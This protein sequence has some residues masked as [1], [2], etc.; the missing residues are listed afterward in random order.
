MCG[1]VAESANRRRGSSLKPSKLARI[2]RRRACAIDEDARVTNITA[3][4]RKPRIKELRRGAWRVRGA[5]RTVEALGAALILPSSSAEIIVL[6]S[7]LRILSILSFALSLAGCSHAASDGQRAGDASFD[8]LTREILQDFYRRH[9][10]AATQLGVHD[11]DNKIEDVSA[12]A[13]DAEVT[14]DSTFRA[15]LLAS[16]SSKL[17]LDQ[18]L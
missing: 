9:P 12:G 6:R 11:Y 1:A 8:R 18:Q 3:D 17:S 14:A 13:F 7:R 10:S 2:A 16:D 4:M 15:R 5:R